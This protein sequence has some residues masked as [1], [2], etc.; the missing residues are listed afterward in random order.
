MAIVS[1]NSEF[2]TNWEKAKRILAPTTTAPSLDFKKWEDSPRGPVFSARL[3]SNHR[4]HLLR[5]EQQRPPRWIAHKMGTH[6]EM[7]HG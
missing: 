5:D 7:G 4:V 6:K 2:A 1:T 3:N